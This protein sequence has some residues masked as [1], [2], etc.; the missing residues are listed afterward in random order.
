M[1]KNLLSKVQQSLQ[2]SNQQQN[3]QSQVNNFSADNQQMQQNQHPEGSRF[4]IDDIMTDMQDF[5]QLTANAKKAVRIKNITSQSNSINETQTLQHQHDKENIK[6]VDKNKTQYNDKFTKDSS[7]NQQNNLAKQEKNMLTDP[8]AQGELQQNSDNEEYQESSDFKLD[9]NLQDNSDDEKDKQLTFIEFLKQNSNQSQIQFLIDKYHKSNQ[10]GQQSDSMRLKR[11][12]RTIREDVLEIVQQ[13]E[14][15]NDILFNLDPAFQNPHDQEMTKQQLFKKEISQLNLPIDIF[16]L[17]ERCEELEKINKV[18]NLQLSFS[19]MKHSDEFVEGMANIKGLQDDL[20]HVKTISHNSRE[21]VEFIKKKV[22]LNIHKS[23]LL[24]RK[25]ERLQIVKSLTTNLL[26]KL[27]ILTIKDKMNQGLISISNKYDQTS[28][29]RII[30]G[31]SVLSQEQAEPFE[32]QITDKVMEKFRQQ[33]ALSMKK[34]LIKYQSNYEKLQLIGITY[35]NPQINMTI[36]ISLDL[37]TRELFDLL[38]LSNKFIEIGQEFGG[39][40][41][42]TG[43]MSLLQYIVNELTLRYINEFKQQQTQILK[44]LLES[45]EWERVPIPDKF[46]IKEIDDPLSEYPKHLDKILNVF[47]NFNKVNTSSESESSGSSNS[48]LPQRKQSSKIISHFSQFALSNP[49]EEIQFTSNQKDQRPDLKEKSQTFIISM[50]DQ[51]MSED[52]ESPNSHNEEDF[53]DIGDEGFKSQNINSQLHNGFNQ[54][55]GASKSLTIYQQYSKLSFNKNVILSQSCLNLLKGTISRY[56]EL[57]NVCRHHSFDL[58]ISMS[59][60]FELYTFVVFHMFTLNQQYKRTFDD[61]PFE[62]FDLNSN[63]AQDLNEYGSL[64]DLFIHQQKY[65]NLRMFMIRVRNIAEQNFGTHQLGVQMFNNPAQAILAKFLPNACIFDHFSKFE[66]D[67]NLCLYKTIIAVES[68]TFINQTLSTKRQMFKK[69]VN[70][71]QQAYLIQYFQNLDQSVNEIGHF[72]YSQ[73]IGELLNL[74]QSFWGMSYLNWSI[75]A[76]KSEISSYVEKITN[77]IDALQK[78]KL[79]KIF[80]SSTTVDRNSTSGQVITVP[81][82]IE[83]AIIEIATDYISESLLDLIGQIKKCNDLGRQSLVQDVN[84]LKQVIELKIQKQPESLE[85][86]LQYVK[87]Y[88]FSREDLLDYI[89][90]NAENNVSYNQVKTLLAL[91]P[92]VNQDIKNSEKKEFMANV[93]IFYRDFFVT[94]MIQNRSSHQF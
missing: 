18:V 7:Q 56:I 6:I 35:S 89:K 3:N 36:H 44:N 17:T 48:T 11:P 68:L 54:M 32:K 51:S 46:S 58:F 59:Q 73:S 87:S 88:F 94:F 76:K 19:V 49:F 78:V 41:P 38:M 71:Q 85:V 10:K 47:S 91:C 64:H 25:M 23:L 92:S 27:Q 37:S 61:T 52:E 55:D 65:K 24:K 83:V 72:L 28:Y 33:V 50:T 53:M 62:Q 79:P 15:P 31:L 4:M 70:A 84:Y 69:L 86:L 93:E 75:K 77:S 66:Q 34:S 40:E 57:M 9:Q 1:F 29:E 39:E 22:A 67:L 30:L 5:D 63:K 21:S 12:L 8:L 20:G 2:N 82:H 74:D 43:Q 80:E 81:S 90:R 13:L 14:N 60:V 16:Q 45:E 42:E 26:F